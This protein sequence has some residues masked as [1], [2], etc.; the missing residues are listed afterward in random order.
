MAVTGDKQIIAAGGYPTIRLYS[1]ASITSEAHELPFENER[2][3]SLRPGTCSQAAIQ[4]L[5][6]HTGNVVALG[7]FRDQT[8]MWSCSDDGTIRLWDLLKNNCTLVLSTGSANNCAVMHPREHLLLTGDDNGTL[9]LWDMVAMLDKASVSSDYTRFLLSEATI[10]LTRSPP[11][12]MVE[13]VSPIQSIC[14]APDGL[15]FAAIDRAGRV[16]LRKIKAEKI[17]EEVSLDAD[18]QNHSNTLLAHQDYGTK[19]VFSPDGKLL[20]TCSSDRTARLWTIVEDGLGLVVR[21][22]RVFEG[23]TRWVWDAAFSADGAYLLTASSDNT[24][25]LWEVASG[26]SVAIYSGHCKAVKAMALNDLPITI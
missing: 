11:T 14:L 10:P 24:A 2:P 18:Q 21:L 9:R 4:V 15:L 3:A 19:C 16:H 1:V 26:D 23:H 20:L 6:G 8:R 13:T 5:E 17:I 22:F 12:A 25:R 7:F